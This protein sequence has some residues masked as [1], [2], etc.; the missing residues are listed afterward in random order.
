MSPQPSSALQ[1]G[2]KLLQKYWISRREPQSEARGTY[3]ENGL[4]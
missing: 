2:V 1:K 4:A 3:K